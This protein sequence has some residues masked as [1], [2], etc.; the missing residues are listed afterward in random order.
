MGQFNTLGDS[1]IVDAVDVVDEQVVLPFLQRFVNAPPQ[2]IL[3]NQSLILSPFMEMLV[4]DANPLIVLTS[5]PGSKQLAKLWV[6][7]GLINVYFA[8]LGII[9]R[10]GII[11][12]QKG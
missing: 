9:H 6:E 11:E 1:E 2:F 8:P 10:N 7:V 12:S 5:L 4:F 3:S